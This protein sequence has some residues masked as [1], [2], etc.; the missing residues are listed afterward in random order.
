MCN[1]N[2]RT[3]RITEKRPIAIFDVIG[4]SFCT[5]DTD[6][7]VTLSSSETTVHYQLK[8]WGGG[9]MYT[10]DVLRLNDKGYWVQL[11]NGD[12]NLNISVGVPG[13]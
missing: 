9:S 12:S 8:E 7:T 2:T 5:G 1:T 3:A 10:I 13:W 4:S 11:T 6:A